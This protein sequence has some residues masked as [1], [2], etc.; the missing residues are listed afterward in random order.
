MLNTSE[1]V[2]D[3]VIDVWID[4][5]VDGYTLQPPCAPDDIEE[6]VT[7]VV[8]ILRERSVY[9][10]AYDNQAIRGRCNLPHPSKR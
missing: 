10:T 9:R 6:F 3:A 4:G 1:E 5:P 7:K 2:A 8:P